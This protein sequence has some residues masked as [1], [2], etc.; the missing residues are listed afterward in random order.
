M[1]VP[2]PPRLI[3]SG[4]RVKLLEDLGVGVEPVE[5]ALERLL[6]A[7]LRLPA[8]P[9]QLAAVEHDQRAVARPA[10]EAARVLDLGVHAHV[11]GDERH[12]VVNHDRLVGAQ[13]VDLGHA[14]VV[15][16][17]G[18]RS[19]DAVDAVLHVQVRLLLAA[20]PQHA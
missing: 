1:S 13:V 12:R 11:L 5:C 9:A 16:V 7:Q 6:D 15:L 2:P 18:H 3:L 8:E 19:L 4:A 20:V 14:L 10:A 17:R